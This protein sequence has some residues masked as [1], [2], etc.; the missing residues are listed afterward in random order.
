MTALELAE[1]LEGMRLP[2]GYNN[3]AL[4]DAAGELR[5][6]LAENE[7]LRSDAARYRWLR[8]GCKTID[9]DATRIAADVWGQEWD[10]AIDAAMG[11]AK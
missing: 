7:A 10:A 4:K 11:E 9:G 5:R 1:I 2:A 6:L 8:E 3:R